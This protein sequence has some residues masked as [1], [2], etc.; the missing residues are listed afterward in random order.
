MEAAPRRL[1]APSTTGCVKRRQ[2]GELLTRSFSTLG[3]AKEYRFSCG[4][5]PMGQILRARYPLNTS[6]RMPWRNYR[7]GREELRCS[8]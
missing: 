1:W 7:C 8:E 2:M 3:L 6:L 5:V 4:V